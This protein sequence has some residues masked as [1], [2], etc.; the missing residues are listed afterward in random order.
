[1]P[2]AALIVSDMVCRVPNATRIESVSR[3]RAGEISDDRVE[4]AG[5]LLR[6]IVTSIRSVPAGKVSVVE[7]RTPVVDAQAERVSSRRHAD[8]EMRMLETGEGKKIFV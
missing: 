5:S 8:G 7:T 1:M 3:N 4:M 2:R 6:P